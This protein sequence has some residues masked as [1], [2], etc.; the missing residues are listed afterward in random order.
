MRNLEQKYISAIEKSIERFGE[1]QR[2][3]VFDKDG[4]KAIVKLIEDL[5]GKRPVF[6]LNDP[7]IAKG[8]KAALNMITE[9]NKQL[10]ALEKI[11]PPADWKKFHRSLV[12]SLSLQLEGYQEMM[13]V[14]ND[15]NFEHINLGQLKVNQGMKILSARAKR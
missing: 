6:T 1:I 5:E 10:E 3:F 14:F 13:L 8:K 2:K 7:L 12:A 9:L 11:K 4:I 15:N